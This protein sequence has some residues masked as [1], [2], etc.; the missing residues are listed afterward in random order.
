MAYLCF[1]AARQYPEVIFLGTGSSIP[2]KVRNTSAILLN[3]CPDKSVILDCAE[4]TFIQ[5][6]RYYGPDIDHILQNIRAI[7]VSHLH[8]DHHLGLIELLKRRRDAFRKS[9]REYL[10]VE[11][12][13]PQQIMIWLQQYHQTF[14]SILNDFR[15]FP[16]AWFT[17][18][19]GTNEFK[20]YRD[21]VNDLELKQVE[22]VPVRHCRHAFGIALTHRDDWKI[23]YSGDT[24][25]CESLV[26]AGMDC[27][28]LIHEATMEDYLEEEARMKKHSTT[29]QAI[30]QGIQMKAKFTLLTHFSQR[31]AKVPIFTDNFG[32]NVGIAFDNLRVN[33]DELHILPHLTP[34]LMAMFAEDYEEMQDK[35]AK[36]IL[37][38]SKQEA[39]LQAHIQQT[40][41][42]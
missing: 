37:Q 8:A 18:G 17:I 22:A 28:L 40:A 26:N 31:Y 19:K 5:L 33:L 39:L 25:P 10:P 34:A 1:P 7:F 6:Y 42:R 2:S 32:S 27:D 3:L 21:L 13:A 9:N 36:K 24:M 29:S 41:A 38:R 16:N 4:G 12:L 30:K 20:E 35:T 11:L 15:L 23:V 14:E